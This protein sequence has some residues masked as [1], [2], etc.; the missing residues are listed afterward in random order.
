VLQG[1]EAARVAGCRG[2]KIDSMVM[3]GANEDE[4]GDLIE[5]GKRAGAE[6]RFIE[7]MDVGGATQ[8]SMSKVFPRAEILQLLNRRYGCIEPVVEDNS[9]PAEQFLLPD[10]TSWHHRLNN[11]AVLPPLRPQPADR[12]RHVVSLSLRAKWGEFAQAAARRRLAG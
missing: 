3:R 11:H 6:V 1:I 8:W 2:L 10:G 4:L 12:G 5:F 7:Y 9:A